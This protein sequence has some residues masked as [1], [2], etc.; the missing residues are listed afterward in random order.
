MSE[1][2]ALYPDS[3]PLQVVQG[4]F[5]NGPV[6]NSGHQHSQTQT[7]R[8]Q[9]HSSPE[10]H[11]PPPSSQGSGVE[12]ALDSSRHLQMDFSGQPGIGTEPGP[13]QFDVAV[14]LATESSMPNPRRVSQEQ[15]PRSTSTSPLVSA[16]GRPH[17]SDKPESPHLSA[18]PGQST[19]YR[20][21]S[22][23]DGVSSPS[24]EYSKP[25]T[26]HGSQLSTSPSGK[27]KQ[28]EGHGPAHGPSS[29]E[30][31]QSTLYTGSSPSPTQR[32]DA[33]RVP[34]DRPL[35]ESG[36]SSGDSRSSSPPPLPPSPPGIWP[37]LWV[38]LS[39]VTRTV[40]TQLRAPGAMT[41]L[42][43]AML[44]AAIS[45]LFV[46]I[47][48]I[49][50]WIGSFS[51]LLPL[52]ATLLCTSSTIGAHV[53]CMVLGY[54]SLAA[55]FG[56]TLLGRFAAEECNRR[57]VPS[58][59]HGARAILAVWLFVGL[60]LVSLIRVRHRRYFIPTIL[61]CLPLTLVLTTNVDSTTGA[62]SA[63]W[64]LTKPFVFGA[65]IALV[66]GIFVFPVSAIFNLEK[67]ILT[68]MCRILTVLDITT[69][70]FLLRD[71]SALLTPQQFNSHMAKVRQAMS[72]LK[73]AALVAKYEISYSNHKPE[74][75]TAI[76]KTLLTISQHLGSMVL[77][78][79]NERY[80]VHARDFVDHQADTNSSDSDAPHVGPPQ[81]GVPKQLAKANRR[82]FIQLLRNFAPSIQDLSYLCELTLDR[83]AHQF[84]K[85]CQALGRSSA[86]PRI[87]ND[88]PGNLL[89]H[90]YSLIESRYQNQPRS[91]KFGPLKSLY[92]RLVEW[93]WDAKKMNAS[94]GEVEAK[95]T[96]SAS[97]GVVDLNQVES[98][99]NLADGPTSSGSI[100]IDVNHPGYF[101]QPV[102]RRLM[103]QLFPKIA[104]ENSREQSPEPGNVHQ[105]TA[106]EDQPSPPN[107]YSYPTNSKPT[108]EIFRRPV[109]SDY[110][111]ADSDMQEFVDRVLRAIAQLDS[112][113]VSVIGKVCRFPAGF[114]G[115]IA[116]LDSQEGL[117]LDVPKPG[118][119]AD[120]PSSESIAALPLDEFSE[121][122][123][124]I[125]FFLFSLREVAV[126]LSTLMTQIHTLQLARSQT[127]RLWIRWNSDAWKVFHYFRVYIID[128]LFNRRQRRSKNTPPTTG[129]N[130]NLAGPG[131][132]SALQQRRSSQEKG[133]QHR[134]CCN[135]EFGKLPQDSEA[136]H[137]TG[138][139]VRPSQ[140]RP[141]DNPS[142]TEPIL[143]RRRR[144]QPTNAPATR[145]GGF[146]EEY[147]E[148]VQQ[149]F[150]ENIDDNDSE[151]A[152]EA[153]AGVVTEPPHARPAATSTRQSK[154]WVRWRGW[155][156][157]FRPPRYT[158]GERREESVPAM[159]GSHSLTH[160]PE[161]AFPHITVV[162]QSDA[163][164]SSA[165]PPS[166]G[167]M[168]TESA[169]PY[170]P[171]QRLSTDGRQGSSRNL[172]EQSDPAV[173]PPSKWASF[174]YGLWLISQFLKSGAVQYAVKVS[175]SISVICLPAW[176]DTSMDFY[177]TQRVEWI[178][179]VV[180]I[181]L[182]P[183][184]GRTLLMSI[185]RVVGT[186]YAVLVSLI[187]WHMTTGNK[188]G[189][190]IVSIV[191]SAPAFYVIIFT[192]HKGV[193]YLSSSVYIITVFTLYTNNQGSDNILTL[194][195][196]R[197]WTSLAGIVVALLFNAWLWPR[198]ARVELRHFTALG[199]DTLGNIYSQ[200]TAK[201]VIHPYL[202]SRN[203]F[204][205]LRL[206]QDNARS[207]RQEGATTTRRDSAHHTRDV[208]LDPGYPY[209]DFP[210]PSAA[211][212]PYDH[213][214][215]SVTKSTR[216]MQDL[217]GRSQIMLQESMLEP[218][219]RGPFPAA[220]YTEILGRL[221]NILDRFI[222]M[223]VTTN[224][225]SPEVHR[226][227]IL[228]FNQHGRRDLTAA[229]L[230]N[231]YALAGALRSK[232]P[233]PP[234]LPSG[235]AARIRLIK[236]IRGQMDPLHQSDRVGV[237]NGPAVLVAGGADSGGCGDS[238]TYEIPEAL[239]GTNASPPA[240][241]HSREAI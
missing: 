146:Y 43:R 25:Y 233:L 11:P 115:R 139:Q 161:Y 240:T 66:T 225:I 228:P 92:R 220:V 164:A 116:P 212:E 227:L 162:E 76:Q 52:G 238:I 208:V 205:K 60:F 73:E 119:T 80:L 196:K 87:V 216:K 9:P 152:S 2:S 236:Q 232:T 194:T 71:S 234:Y 41:V 184:I 24:P 154:W 114:S 57:F 224:Y 15:N 111:L 106:D 17:Y 210:P 90:G 136:A 159:D 144:H 28:L 192:P 86:L 124:L 48:G 158:K 56:Y 82:V 36:S 137:S 45:T 69:R 181:V 170:T 27:L 231:F 130:D 182:S 58:G 7:Q 186:V 150:E 32:L 201:L 4:P 39:A 46:L 226:A 61:F 84:I 29:M 166:Q 147:R 202:N 188:Y 77:S 223:S 22:S 34:S 47:D 160:G 129:S 38:Y 217:L 50:R 215:A 142:G 79:Q 120:G 8:M 221:Q 200:L 177:R 178:A 153:E 81:T 63:M 127:R 107:T 59:N 109:C 123:F 100:V 21:S 98:N 93:F 183:T 176:F 118:S 104:P 175:L 145:I 218:R 197:L 102:E 230:I 157:I 53:E 1:S 173:N 193:G 214:Q 33:G 40:M 148:I 222:S 10:C 171:P 237:P 211:L 94:P 185:Y 108:D 37:R 97:S 229:I 199:L 128:S 31:N 169:S 95:R 126:L 172:A 96:S 151:S 198:I 3:P 72:A 20:T 70:A 67:H 12:T 190:F 101:N 85:N 235:R 83:S 135:K 89:I 143:R 54:V 62:F 203:H 140:Y 65:N 55:T 42:I 195:Y 206:E 19:D 133:P 213:L 163:R 174:L 125:F 189:L 141:T 64:S 209:I 5:T 121:E 16:P 207:D 51:F 122:A 168:P 149:V 204:F 68:V 14:P 110:P 99:M 155:L 49:E 6:V 78:A 138:V 44:T 91:D 156:D 131:Q 132:Q 113:E 30:L 191:F 180:L 165:L 241:P 75:F 103:S 219:L 35:P 134:P 88:V 187:G 13:G 105:D 179:I 18:L 239:G 117:K 74:D 112:L 167:P 23:T 26:S